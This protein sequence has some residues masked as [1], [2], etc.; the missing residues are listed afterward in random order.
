M[1]QRFA[2]LRHS[3]KVLG[4]VVGW[5]GLFCARSPRVCVVQKPTQTRSAFLH[6]QNTSHMYHGFISRQFTDEDLDPVCSSL[7]IR[8][9]YVTILGVIFLVSQKIFFFV[10]AVFFSLV[11]CFFFST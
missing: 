9:I 2:R 11:F 8:Y 5:G 1:A 7:Y 6:N 3:K 4:S 10:S